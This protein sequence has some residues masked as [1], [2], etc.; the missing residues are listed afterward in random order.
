M[1]FLFSHP[2]QITAPVK[3]ASM[4]SDLTQAG[5]TNQ[6]SKT[7]VNHFLFCSRARDRHSLSHEV[8]VQIDIS[9]GHMISSMHK[10]RLIRVHCQTTDTADEKIS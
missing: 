7:K 3:L 8:F 1:R 4:F 6:L 10:Y 5:Q 2:F 9:M